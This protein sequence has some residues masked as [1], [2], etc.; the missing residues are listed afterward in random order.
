M[1]FS[2]KKVTI[3]QPKVVKHCRNIENIPD[4]R[5][6]KRIYLSKR[7]IRPIRPTTGNHPGSRCTCLPDSALTDR[8]EPTTCHPR[9]SPLPQVPAADT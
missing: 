8:K 1:V 6:I 2:D 3:C 5:N 7:K 4:I 9:P